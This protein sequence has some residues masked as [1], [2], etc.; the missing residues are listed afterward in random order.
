MTHQDSP[1]GT[2]PVGKLVLQLAIPA[3]LAQFVNILYSVVD[4][5]YVGHI[6][7]AGDAALA[8]VGVCA[9]VVT[10]ITALGALIGFVFQ[11][12]F[13]VFLVFVQSVEFGNVFCEFVVDF[14]HFFGFDSFHFASENGF[15]AGK[16]FAGMLSG[17]ISIT[18]DA[19]NNLSDAGSSIITI[20]GFKMAAQRADEEHPY[21]HARMEYVAT[22]AVAAIIL[23]MGFELFRDSFG[24]IIKPQDIE[25]SWLIV[26]ILLAS[27]AVK[28]VMAVYNFYFSKKL[29]SSTL[30]ATGRDSLSD[31]IATS[32][33]LAATLIA[34]FLGLNLDG[35][36]G[37]FVS[38][39][40]FYS[41]ISSA[42]EAIDP[43][44]GAKPEPEF[45]DRLKEMVL[46]FDKNIL[47]MHDLMVHD[48]GPG[49]RIVSFHAEVPEDGDM[50]ELHD[51][52]DNLERR[53][54]RELGC[55]VT[56]H[57]D[58]VAIEDEEVAGLKAEVLSVIKGL[59]SHINMHDFRIIRGDTHTNLVFDIAVPF[60]YI[61]SDDDICNAIQENVRK[62]LGK[63]YYTVIEV[64]RDNYINI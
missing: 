15:F 57:M 12:F 18:A 29:D 20:A 59:D 49:H 23:I 6:A 11:L 53:I 34:H 56:I 22:L 21:G 43:L 24:K 3:M 36:G 26:A 61:T 1:L 7:N 37:V 45:V 41:G 13:D 62:K 4:R 27:I 38:L 31:C 48:Y 39:F 5:M 46:D 2:A 54:R 28:C 25:F 10:M 17:A 32:V 51:I 42:R 35:I 50:V 9:P 47:G 64:D 52:I 55:I 58:P 19:F 16:L 8:G 63:N 60:G 14:R 33:V 44:L 30:E 40:I